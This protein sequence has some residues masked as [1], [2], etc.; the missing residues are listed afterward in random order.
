MLITKFKRLLKE[1]H[2]SRSE[3]QYDIITLYPLYVY[4]SIN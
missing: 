3:W 2:G 4:Q 1:S